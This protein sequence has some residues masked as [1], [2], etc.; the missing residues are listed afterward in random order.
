MM[1]TTHTP[2]PWV[3]KG[4]HVLKSDGS[5]IRQERPRAAAPEAW[6]EINARHLA[7]AELIASAPELADKLK[8]LEEEYADE[9]ACHNLHVSEMLEFEKDNK[10][11]RSEMESVQSRIQFIDGELE[12][13]V[14]LLQ[15]DYFENWDEV[16]N[17]L[18]A[19]RK[20]TVRM[21]GDELSNIRKEDSRVS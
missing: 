17:I 3:I 6:E 18:C 10:R 14:Q 5:M 19:I 21:L 2:G 16:V 13:S 11:L 12:K 9:R 15:D 7:D 20:T 4:Y 1:K 8:H